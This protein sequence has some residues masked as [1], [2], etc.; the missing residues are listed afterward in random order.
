M[1]KLTVGPWVAAQKLP[2]KDLALDRL[3]FLE[4][5]RTRATTPTV[6]GLPLIGMGGS[7][8]KPCFALPYTLIWTDANTRA[9][10]QLAPAF[11]CFVEYGVYPHLKLHDGGQEVAAVQD[12]TTCATVYLR[13]GYRQAE[14][15]LT[16]LLETLRP[17]VQG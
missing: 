1:T 14:E 9:L 4:R 11:G 12:W 17:P 2:S 7:C 13:P 5:S 6:A 8:G 10:E 3:A 16:R 15:L